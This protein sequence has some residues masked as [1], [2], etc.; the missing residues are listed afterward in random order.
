VPHNI[1]RHSHPKAKPE[2]D[3][4]DTTRPTGID[5]L[6]LLDDT[7]TEILRRDERIGYHALYGPADGQ[8]DGQY[9][10]PVDTD[11]TDDGDANGAVS[12]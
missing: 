6:K 2:I 3:T 9:G 7:H 4:T 12:A 5:Y 8:L 1:T 10:L 11:D